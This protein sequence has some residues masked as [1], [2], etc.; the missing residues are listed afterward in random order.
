M[1]DQDV[2]RATSALVQ[3]RVAL[4]SKADPRDERDAFDRA[5][6]AVQGT[7]EG[8][9]LWRMKVKFEDAYARR[10]FEEFAKIGDEFKAVGSAFDVGKKMADAKKN[11]LFFPT[12]AAEL[13]RVADIVKALK[14]AAD[15]LNTDGIAGKIEAGDVQGILG[16]ADQI[17]TTLQQLHQK[18][19]AAQPASK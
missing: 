6:Q 19:T 17:S 12:A 5:Y 14:A 7:T 9:T 1:T 3:Y 13:S 16:Q 11:S 18:L 10:A 8:D 4:E 2:Y 15:K